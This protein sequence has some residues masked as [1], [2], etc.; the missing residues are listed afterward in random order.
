[1]VQSRFRWAIGLNNEDEKDN[2]GEENRCT[3]CR[4]REKSSSLAPSSNL[5]HSWFACHLE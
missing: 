1:V 3:V 4:W 5:L 2:E